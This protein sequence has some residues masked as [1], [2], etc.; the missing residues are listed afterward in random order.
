MRQWLADELEADLTASLEPFTRRETRMNALRRFKYRHL[1]RIGCRDI[2]GDADLTVTTEE[3]SHLADV[4]LGGGLAM[5]G[6][7]ADGCPR[8]AEG[9]GRDADGA[10]GV[11]HGQARRRRAELFLRRRPDRRLRRRRGHRGRPRWADRQRRL[12]RRGGAAH[13][14]RA[15]GGHRGGPRLPRGSEIAS[16]GPDGG[17]RPLA[18]R[19]SRL[20]R[21]PGRAL[22]APGAD[23]GALLCGRSGG[24]RALPRDGPPL[25]LPA[26]PR[27]RDRRRGAEDEGCDRPVASRQGQLAP[28]RQARRG[29]HSRGG[30]PRPG[31]PAPLRG[32]RPLA[33]REEQLA[34]DLPPHRARLSLA[35]PRA[36]ARRRA[37]PPAHGRASP[38]DPP[39]VPDAHASG[40]GGG[41]RAPRAA[42][43]HRP[44]AGGGAP[45]LPRRARAHHARRAPGVSRV[46]RGAARRRRTRGPHPELYRA[47]GHRLH[48][49]RS[50]APEPAAPPGR[51]APHPVSRGGAPGAH[52]DV[53]RGARRALA[54]ARSRTR[55]STSSSAS[56][57][58]RGRA[59][60]I[61]SCSPRAPIC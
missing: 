16:G 31:A 3:L 19:L 33:A 20:P 52:R 7:I 38:A 32:R 43:G 44:A 29:R 56:S 15:R 51:P 54:D 6:R 59:P 5:G 47:Q 39:R 4:C 21:G 41:A 8:R 2:L 53:P 60:R 40:R 9:A 14:G 48:R 1:L 34:R 23:Q 35:R 57:R 61:S 10:R 28:Q 37:H 46:L 13:R 26:G 24:G 49:S 11:R 18:R 50:R 25:R 45:P 55:P 22:G 58:R 12:L 27:R 36:L 17:P 30:V 42:H